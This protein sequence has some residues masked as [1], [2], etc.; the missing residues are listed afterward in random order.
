MLIKGSEEFVKAKFLGS[1]LVAAS[2]PSSLV[3]YDVRKP[4]IIV[5]EVAHTVSA[6]KP[7]DSEDEINDFDIC[8]SG[9]SSF[10]L[11]AAF[12]S[13]DCK[14][15]KLDFSDGFSDSEEKVLTNKHQNICLKARFGKDPSLVYSCGFDYKVI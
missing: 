7:R 11:V 2:T 6:L 5:T 14:I 8:P 15:A 3:V 4:S 10:N 13:G 9:P 12:D 1:E